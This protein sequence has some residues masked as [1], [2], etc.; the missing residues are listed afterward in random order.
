MRLARGEAMRGGAGRDLERTVVVRGAEQ[1]RF[2]SALRAGVLRRAVS[3][4]GTAQ[5]RGALAAAQRYAGSAAGRRGVRT[6]LS[7]VGAQCGV[8]SVASSATLA[9]GLGQCRVNQRSSTNARVVVFGARGK[10][11]SS[12]SS[13]GANPSIERT[14]SSKLESAAHVER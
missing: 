10:A 4:R 8:R 11:L 1:A 3:P 12:L 14:A 5:K 2:T 13:L 6:S 9:G 7:W